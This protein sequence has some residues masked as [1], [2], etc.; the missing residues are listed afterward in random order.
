MGR[1]MAALTIYLT[2]RDTLQTLGAL[3]PGYV[4]AGDAEY[5]FKDADG[6]TFVVKPAG[7]LSSA[8]RE[9]TSG[10]R[11]GESETITKAEEDNY[12][13]Q[14]EKKWGKYIPGSLTKSPRFIPGTD[15]KT[16]PVYSEGGGLEVGWVDEEGVHYYREPRRASA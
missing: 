16:L 9:F 2:A 12:R 4:S 1:A 13:A 14:A 15:R 11:K 5:E 3:Q 8:K 7:W 6:S 10:P